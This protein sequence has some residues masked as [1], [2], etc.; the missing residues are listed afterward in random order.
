MLWTTRLAVAPLILIGLGLVFQPQRFHRTPSYANLL[1]I[2][3]A[4]T[5][6]ALYLFVAALLITWTIRQA[7]HWWGIAVHTVAVMLTAGWLG[8]FVVRWLT[9][10]ATTIVNVASWAVFLALVIKSAVAIVDK[11]VE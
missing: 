4:P 1:H 6:G 10:G 3:P 2:A 9:D 8:A 5:W 11:P 7:P